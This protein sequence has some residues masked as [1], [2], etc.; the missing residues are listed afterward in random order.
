MDEAVEEGTI[1]EEVVKTF[2]FQSGEESSEAEHIEEEEFLAEEECEE[3]GSGDGFFLTR[4]KV[5]DALESA[6]ESVAERELDR[7][8]IGDL[9]AF[10]DEV[11]PQKFE[12]SRLAASIHAGKG[13]VFHR[14]RVSK[15]AILGN[16][17]RFFG[18]ETG[19][20]E[21]KIIFSLAVCSE[22][23]GIGKSRLFISRLLVKSCLCSAV[24]FSSVSRKI[25]YLLG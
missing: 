23:E 17:R 2:V 24:S 1:G 9:V 7:M 11:F 25:V 3:R 21:V 12:L 13:D 18:Y 22:A 6:G 10:I 4:L 5:F 19:Y 8:K 16:E 20:Q 15:S 14:L